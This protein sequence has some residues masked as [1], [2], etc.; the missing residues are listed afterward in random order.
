MLLL[1]LAPDGFAAESAMVPPPGFLE[2]LG[3]MVEADGELI[4]PL[5]L[6]SDLERVLG[7]AVRTASWQEG[8]QEPELDDRREEPEVRP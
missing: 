7:E 1:A 3:A 2:F 6:E 8:I 5:S 4:D